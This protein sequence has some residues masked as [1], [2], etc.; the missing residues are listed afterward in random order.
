MTALAGQVALVTG[1]SRGIGA[2]V[3]RALAADG[4]AV[5]VNYRTS[6]VDA[7]KVVDEIVAEGGRALA[8]GAD[9]ADAEAVRAMTRR[10]LDELGGLDV[11]VNNAGVA[12]DGLLHTMAPEDWIPVMHTNFGGVFNCTTSVLP[13]FMA[14]GSGVIVNVSSVLGE[15]GWVGTAN[16]AASKGAI[17]AFTLSC[18]VEHARF[19]VRVNAVLP[20]FTPT[21]LVGDLAGGEAARGIRRQVPMRALAGVEQ[22]AKAVRFLSGPE[23]DY[24]TGALVPVD[25]GATAALGLGR[26]R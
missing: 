1:G 8:F 22:V 19:G 16:Y 25:G 9:V 2:A 26:P 23:S 20:G 4:A 6:E 17:N 12:R 5:A 11:L 13:H 7:H 3:C 18:A 15:R 10:V 21:D 14:K 24:L